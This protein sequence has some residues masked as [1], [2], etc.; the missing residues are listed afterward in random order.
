MKASSISC[1]P[2]HASVIMAR[3]GGTTLHGDNAALQRGV[4]RRSA[5]CGMGCSP[6]SPAPPK[7]DAIS[8]ALNETCP[9]LEPRAAMTAPAGLVERPSRTRPVTGTQGHEPVPVVE[10]PVLGIE[11]AV[12]AHRSVAGRQGDRLPPVLQHAPLPSLGDV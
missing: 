7:S 10:Q 1:G 3:A 8:L 11:A 4:P 12:V 5:T 9:T 2:L 6:G